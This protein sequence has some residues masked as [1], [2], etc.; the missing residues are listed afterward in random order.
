MSTTLTPTGFTAAPV[1][2]Q[3]NGAGQIV[4]LNLQN[5]SSTALAAQPTSFGETF[6]AGAVKSTDQLTATING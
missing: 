4:G 2:P 1:V 5:T 6:M 3:P